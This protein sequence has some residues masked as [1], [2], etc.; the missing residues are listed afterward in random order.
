[1]IGIDLHDNA[2][3]RREESYEHVNFDLN[4]LA[5]AGG[6]S[7]FSKTLLAALRGHL[8]KFQQTSISCLVQSTGVYW[9]GPFLTADDLTRERVLGVNLIGH[10]E[11]LHAVMKLNA[12]AGIDNAACLTHADIGSF[13]G[14]NVRADR[15][16]YASSKAAGIEFAA[17]LNFGKE[18]F[19]S[20]YLAPGPID[21]HMLHRNH[22]VV[23]SHGAAEVL[24]DLRTSDRDLYQKIFVDCDDQALSTLIV[25]KGLSTETSTHFSSYKEHRSEARAAEYG[26][27]GID[28]CA[29]AIAKVLESPSQGPSGVY[30]ITR[31][32]SRGVVVRFTDFAALNRSRMFT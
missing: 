19:R 9:S 20:I 10:I 15:A 22:W 14:L 28:E 23:K 6:F 16:I 24:D 3:L 25:D 32:P 13:Q 21:T 12:E 8:Q 2:L 1:V 17:G 11:V 26:V 31:P 27:L 5:H 7:S 30:L 4:P 29:T 18:V